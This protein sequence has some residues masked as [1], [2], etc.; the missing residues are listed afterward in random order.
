MELLKSSKHLHLLDARLEVLHEQSN[1]WLNEIAF[2]RDELTFFNSLFV[3]KTFNVVP[4]NAKNNIIRIENEIK[5][6]STGELDELELLVKEHEH[7]L[8]NLLESKQDNEQSYREK[9]RQLTHKFYFFENR[10]KSLKAEV[11]D[12]SKQINKEKLSVKTA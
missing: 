6:I 10:L 2:W 3:K 4:I 7:F 8:G 12:L 11:F 5:K 1:D 9:H